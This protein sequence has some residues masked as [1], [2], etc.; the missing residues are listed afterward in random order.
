MSSVISWTSQ[1]E[2]L[3][4]AVVAIG[5][6]DGVHVGHQALVQRTVADAR[7]RDARS[8]VVTFDRDPDQVITPST[9]APQLLTLEDKCERL[10]EQGVDV[11]LVVPFD[12]ALAAVSAEEFLEVVLGTC[13][14]VVA[15][16][17]GRDFRFGHR[18]AGDIDTLY[19][20][21]AE[22]NADV[23]PHDLVVVDRVAVTSTRIRALVA[24]GAV[25]EAAR[26]LGRKHRVAGSVV[27]GRRE[28][29]ALG[30]P[31]ANVEPVS[32]AAIPVDGV[33]AGSAVLEDGR[34]LPAAMSVGVP[35]TFPGARDYL[36]AHILDF[37]EDLY[38]QRI[39]LEFATRLRSQEAF[40]SLE[41]L[42]TAIGRDVES[43][44]RAAVSQRPAFRDSDVVE[45]PL[46]LE[47]AERSV[48]D[49]DPMAVYDIDAEWVELVG[50]RRLSG[51][52]G[53]AGYTAALVSAPLQAAE[54]PFAWDPYPPEE[55]PAFRVG[56]GLV[57]RPFSLLVPADRL[58]EARAVLDH[59]YFHGRS[60]PPSSDLLFMR[61]VTDD[62]TD[63]DVANGDGVANRSH[64]ASE[65]P[66]PVDTRAQ[67]R[68]V[69]IWIVIIAVAVVFVLWR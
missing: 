11:V 33:Y 49:S 35:P 8:V 18:A 54:I 13:C 43:V 65:G 29:R 30:F 23:T 4:R 17:V 58:D 46:A 27:E 3:G 1:I 34:V 24:E 37:D 40:G 16:H 61:P 63:R 67:I 62:A 25:Q 55:M 26:L 9:A 51:M 57:D 28:G 68:E 52:F 10:A 15:I 59:A 60:A 19:V 36:E 50:P 48:A 69:I 53:D 12:E 20:W 7:R 22:H 47:A 45:D 38:G 6:F 14:T 41:E 56:Y 66:A 2:P 44:R 5:V 32:Y 21:A 64:D 31:T 39:V 42:T